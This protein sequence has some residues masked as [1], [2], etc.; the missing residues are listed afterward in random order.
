MRPLSCTAALVAICDMAQI[1][2]SIGKYAEDAKG[3]P[4]RIAF[5]DC[6][7]MFVELFALAGLGAPQLINV[8]TYNAGQS[9]SNPASV[10]ISL[11]EP[12]NTAFPKINVNFAALFG[13]VGQSA[14]QEVILMG[15]EAGMVIGQN[16]PV[17]GTGDPARVA[18]FKVNS[19]FTYLYALI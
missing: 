17:I 6:N 3:T 16:S 4:A 19:N 9:P 2:I 14:L 1:H 10:P 7:T 18:W 5:I 11:G 13:F 8:G 15:G 12:S